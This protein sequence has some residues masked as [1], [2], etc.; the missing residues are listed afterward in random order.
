MQNF[1]VFGQKSR[2][3][4]REF[5]IMQS[6]CSII[7]NNKQSCLASRLAFLQQGRRAPL[8]RPLGRLGKLPVGVPAAEL[9]IFEHNLMKAV[10]RTL[11]M[12]NQ[13]LAIKDISTAPPAIVALIERIAKNGYRD[14]TIPLSEI[15]QA[16]NK[17]EVET[18]VEIWSG[19]PF[20]NISIVNGVDM[21][22]A[23]AELVSLF[24]VV[25]NRLRFSEKDIVD[26]D[27]FYDEVPEAPEGLGQEHNVPDFV[28]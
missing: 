10:C 22:S 4:V 23:S 9:S 1:N 27:Y 17:D 25:S 14:L 13:T 24:Y 15:V 28:D 2:L 3:L 19:R 16:I 26:D 18:E 21:V 5:H 7:Y 8:I 11:V 20:V 12:A 6:P